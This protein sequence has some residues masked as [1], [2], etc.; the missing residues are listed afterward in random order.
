MLIFVTLC[1]ALA[2]K[3]IEYDY[4]PV[5]LVKDG[6]EQVIKENFFLFLF[7]C[8]YFNLAFGMFYHAKFV[9]VYFRNVKYN[10]VVL[11]S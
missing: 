1:A 7:V 8:L 11:H 5:H 3:G 6:G 10:R 4:V 9:P 2:M